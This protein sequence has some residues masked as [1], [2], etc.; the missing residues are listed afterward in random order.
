MSTFPAPVAVPDEVARGLILAAA[1]TD[2]VRR[3]PVPPVLVL[4]LGPVPLVD[5]IAFIERLRLRWW[6]LAVL[7]HQLLGL[8]LRREPLAA[9]RIILRV[10]DPEQHLDLK[11]DLRLDHRVSFSGVRNNVT[12]SP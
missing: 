2:A 5:V 3:R 7:R 10:S 11:R 12:V 1:R 6:R 4:A 9:R 8:A